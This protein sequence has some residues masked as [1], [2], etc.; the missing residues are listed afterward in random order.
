MVK[1]G[2]QI[3]TF[4]QNIEH[5]ALG[6]DYSFNLKLKCTSCGEISEKWQVINETD[7]IETARSETNYL[8]KCKLC[9]RENTLD[10]L[11]D[12][13]CKSVTCYLNYMI[14]YNLFT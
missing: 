2:L 9:S 6:E 12:T 4:F 8:A 7:K 3:K 11:T 14:D 10:I 1:I 5:L 13:K